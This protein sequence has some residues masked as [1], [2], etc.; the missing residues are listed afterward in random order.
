MHPRQWPRSRTDPPPPPRPPP[1][2]PSS[3]PRLSRLKRKL[4]SRW[5]PPLRGPVASC[6]PTRRLRPAAAR[7]PQTAVPR[8]TTPITT[9]VATMAGAATLCRGRTGSC[10]R[11]LRCRRCLLLPRR[12]LSP[13]WLP[14][15]F[16][17]RPSFRRGQR[18]PP[19][20]PRRPPRRP[21]PRAAERSTEGSWWEAS[22]VPCSLSARPHH[23]CRHARG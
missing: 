18:L 10:R 12:N 9:A 22:H 14:R 13:P 5:L 7:R 3:K 19:L 4:R 15:S 11:D 17:P 21:F 1:P 8:T 23:L 20:L 2:P 6:P 16:R